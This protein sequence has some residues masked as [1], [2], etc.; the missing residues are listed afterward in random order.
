MEVLEGVV[1]RYAWGSPT[2]I[3]ALLGTIADGGP[4]AELW[5]GAHPSAPARAGGAGLD[6]LVTTDPEGM[7][8]RRVFERFGARLPFLPKVLAAAEPLSLQAHPTVERATAGFAEETMAGIPLDAPERRYRDADHKP[9]LFC[10]LTP[11]DALCGFRPIDGTLA[12][13][14]RLG[15]GGHPAFAQLASGD[16]RGTVGGLL[17]LP[18]GERGTVAAT[19]ADAA[20]RTD[21]AEATWAR[22][23]AS[24]HPGDPGVG[25]ALLLN[26]VRLQ[27]GEAIFLPDGN[28][29]TYLEGVGIEIMASSDNVLRGG[30]TPKHVDVDE[31]LTVLDVR[32]GPPPVVPA[33]QD[34]PIC[35]YDT[36]VEEFAL[37]LVDLQTTPASIPGD[38]PRVVLCLEGEV[39]LATAADEL[40]L[41]RGMAAWVPACDGPL[42]LRGHGRAVVAT[43]P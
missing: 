7:L 39:V 37:A 25:V 1:R 18:D 26:L 34:G 29:H 23:I 13:L 40:R 3:P 30:L 16:I 15:L 35:R 17:S 2:A 27:P 4:Q 22:R 41:R 8:G 6:D 9:E 42:A 33:R 32:P 43:T 28:L 14:E 24:T 21:G 36:P 10:A 38:R 12:L 31:L 5:L 19:I 11:F 20:A